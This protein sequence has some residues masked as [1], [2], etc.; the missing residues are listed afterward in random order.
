MPSE[1]I[2]PTYFRVGDNNTPTHV[3]IGKSFPV[4][5]FFRE[6]CRFFKLTNLYGFLMPHAPPLLRPQQA[7][8]NMCVPS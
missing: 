2:W 8:K 4:E 7:I 5:N 3:K 1:F 6:L